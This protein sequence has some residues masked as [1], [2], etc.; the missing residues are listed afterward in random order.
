MSNTTGLHVAFL[1]W[2]EI[3]FWLCYC[4]STFSFVS[5][6]PWCPSPYTVLSCPCLLLCLILSGD[7][8]GAK[9]CYLEAIRIRPDFAIGWNNIAGVFKDEGQ[10]DTAIA[11]YREAIRLCPL[12]A[13]S[14][15]N[16]GCVLKES[17][18][19]DEAM[20][21][22]ETAIKLRPDFAIA[23][24]NIGACYYDAGN[25]PKAIASFKHA[26]Q[27]EPNFPDCLVGFSNSS[28]TVYSRRCRCF[29]YLVFGI[30]FR[31]CICRRPSPF[32]VFD[33]LLSCAQ[34]PEQDR[35][36]SSLSFLLFLSA[37]LLT[38]PVIVHYLPPHHTTS[39]P[40]GK[41][42]QCFEGRQSSRWSASML[43]NSPSAE[44]GPSP[45]MEQFSQCPKR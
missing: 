27:L 6:F 1:E 23:H 15:S 25:I 3:Y 20:I 9:R 10:I 40:P 11:Y 35:L 30:C 45:R 16:L 42:G 32:L 29:W 44:A 39:F 13:D 24:A 22:Y 38:F 26:I 12:F 5:L 37:H 21:A 8:E 31:I 28:L 33:H 19:L 2:E 41:H 36:G 18:R 7:L 4:T 34:T 14:Y 17:N 43:Q